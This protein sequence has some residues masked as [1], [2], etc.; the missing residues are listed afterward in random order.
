LGLMDPE[1]DQSNSDSPV[2]SDRKPM[3]SLQTEGIIE[4]MAAAILLREG[5][6]SRNWFFI[7]IGLIAAY[8]A[9]QHFRKMF[10][11]SVDIDAAH[12]VYVKSGAARKSYLKDGSIPIDTQTGLPMDGLV[13]KDDMQEYESD[14]A[15]YEAA[16]KGDD[17]PEPPPD[18]EVAL[19][20]AARNAY[21]KDGS[22]PIDPQTGLPVEG[23]VEKGDMQEYE[24][25]DAAY[26]AALKE[27]SGPIDSQTELPRDGQEEE[28]DGQESIPPYAALKNGSAP[29]IDPRTGSPMGEADEESLKDGSTPTDGTTGLAPDGQHMAETG[30]DNSLFREKCATY[31]V[32]FS[33]IGL[34]SIVII[35]AIVI[36]SQKSLDFRILL[37]IFHIPNLEI[38]V[39]V[40]FLCTLASLILVI[41]VIVKSPTE[42]PGLTQTAS[43]AIG[44]IASS[45][46]AF[47]ILPSFMR[48]SD[49]GKQYEA[50]KN[51]RKLYLAEKI[52]YF[53]HGKFSSNY[54][55]MLQMYA[56]NWYSFFFS[57]DG[58]VYAQ[59]RPVRELP[60]GI[61]AYIKDDSF[62]VVA[63]GQIDNDEVPDVW[64]INE[65][66]ELKHVI[67]DMKIDNWDQLK[68]P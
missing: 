3:I 44:M 52:H 66:G 33:T 20:D 19:L 59:L 38:L 14:D 32:I 35:A 28:S 24:S 30:T 23:L 51:L 57:E 67:D 1:N 62:Q 43:I 13:E 68:K 15:A 45:V 46:L 55:E 31:A 40:S 63:A 17:T 26:E 65:H 21:L 25:D 10:K 5:I 2:T 37:N 53:R 60:G 34:I 7:G 11:Q 64:M 41:I 36:A 16:L 39:P 48:L 47:I 49:P 56:T 4:G 58:H 8:F 18:E 6:E 27:D 50:T 29:I 9:F 12:S 42:E 61:K 22:I 54:Q